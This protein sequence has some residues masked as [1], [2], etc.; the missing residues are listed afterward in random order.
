VVWDVT[1]LIVVNRYERFRRNLLSISNPVNETSSFLRNAGNDPPNLT[2]P[3][4][5]IIAVR[6]ED[7]RYRSAHTFPSVGVEKIG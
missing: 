1:H 3:K 2:A 7:L 5:V 4:T 6:R